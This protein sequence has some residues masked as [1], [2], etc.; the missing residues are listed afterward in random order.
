MFL[1]AYDYITDF[2]CDRLHANAGFLS[3]LRVQGSMELQDPSNV[4]Q[5][6]FVEALS[7]TAADVVSCTSNSLS[8][9]DGRM[10]M[11]SRGG[12]T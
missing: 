4:F 2:K 5:V 8:M 7:V 3:R 1:S 10:T 9:C 6:S 12:I 11:Q